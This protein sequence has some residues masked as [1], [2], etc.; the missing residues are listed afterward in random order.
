MGIEHAE[1]D[2]RCFILIMTANMVESKLNEEDG[3]AGNPLL[4][5]S[6]SYGLL[7]AEQIFREP[8][9]RSE[10]LERLQVYSQL[11]FMISLQTITDGNLLI[12]KE[13]YSFNRT[14]TL[15]TPPTSTDMATYKVY[16]W[17]RREKY[18][19]TNMLV[20]WAHTYG[21][22][23]VGALIG[24]EESRNWGDEVDICKEGMS[25]V[26]LTDFDA[27]TDLIILRV[28]HTNILLVLGSVASIMHLT[29]VTCS[30]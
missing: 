3:Q 11:L 1:G 4:N 13:Q 17:E 18:W 28:L 7:Q 16:D 29:I 15:S 19:K 26:N 21:K 23:D 30:K 20:S 10:V 14:M 2:P 8:V 5:M 22:H 6:N 24:Y 25:S 12:I 9:Y 27:M